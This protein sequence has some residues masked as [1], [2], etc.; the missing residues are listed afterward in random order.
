MTGKKPSASSD[1]KA[2][3]AQIARYYRQHISAGRKFQPGR[4]KVQYAGPVYDEKELTAM[5][6]AI[7][8]GW[9]GVGKYTRRFESRF[10]RFLGARD[11][12]LVNSGSSANLLAVT[13]LVASGRLR[14]G[15]EVL[16]PAV[17]FPTTLNP[18]IQ[19]NLKPV[20]VDI[21]LE[22]FNAN[23]DLLEDAVSPHTR[24]IMLPHTLGIPN[25][26]GRVTALT[27]SHSLSLIEDSCDALGS[28]YDGQ[29]TGTFGTLGTFSFYVAHQMTLGEG[30]AIV[31]NEKD[32]VPVL[33][34]LRDWGRAC[35][36]PICP[37][38]RDPDFQCKQRFT[39]GAEGLPEEYDKR[40]VYQHIGYNLKPVEF[41]AAMGLEQLKKLPSF[42]EARR[43]N[44]Q[45]LY[46][47]ME[48]YQDYFVLPKA[49][50]QA[51]PAWFAFP[52]T[53][54]DNVPFTRKQIVA[55]LEGHNV[56][57]RMLFAG[58]VAR[59]PAYRDVTFRVA[60]ELR[61]SDK[62]MRDSFFVGIYPGLRQEHLDYIAEVMTQFLKRF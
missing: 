9:F 27:R 28:T 8:D 38:T 55:W 54:R 24:L 7:L 34:S 52:V 45:K 62:V 46:S 6:D 29:Y 20:L 5:V 48:E 58:N 25:D 10:S 30:G 26:M 47:V 13:S 17:T 11:A 21:E 4:T 61:N 49:P 2:L 59:Q 57:T 36:C 53:L 15:D 56:E 51:E 12:L 37:V 1:R 39:V 42:V 40:Y 33:R 32:L 18:I 60:G 35:V 50:S 41:Q 23:P 44:F 22:T 31:T 43:R 14:P 3:H 16:T 19:C